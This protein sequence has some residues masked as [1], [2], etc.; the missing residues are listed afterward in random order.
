[1]TNNLSKTILTFIFSITIISLQAANITWIGASSFWDDPTNW[2]TG[3]VPSAAD[4][5]IIPS[6]WVRVPANYTALATSIHLHP[7]TNLQ[8]YPD[9]TINVDGAINKAGIENEGRIFVQGIM[10]ITNV[11]SPNGS[12]GKAI[13]NTNGLFVYSTGLLNIENIE[14]YC[15]DTRAPGYVSNSGDINISNVQSHGVYNTGTFR[16]YSVLDMSLH[17]SNPRS[18]GVYNRGAFNN[19]ANGEIYT[20]RG[21]I[22]FY[23]HYNATLDNHGRIE[24]EQAANSGFRNLAT[25]T[26]NE[27]SSISCNLAGAYGFSNSGTF[28]NY[29]QTN[30]DYTGNTALRNSGTINN[31]RT[32]LIFNSTTMGY[33]GLT[34]STFNNYKSFIVD[35]SA[36]S[37]LYGV[38]LRGSL[39]NHQDGVLS[40][41]ER[42]LALGPLDNYG[43]ISLLYTGNNNLISG[44]GAINNYSVIDDNTNCLPAGTN[45]QKLII[46]PVTGPMQV[47]VPFSNV[48]EVASLAGIN[49]NNWKIGPSNN[50]SAGTY[51]P[52]TN[53]FTP[54]ANA[55]G[56]STIYISINNGGNLSRNHTLELDSPI[57]PFTGG[58]SP[59]FSLDNNGQSFQKMEELTV[60][61]NP[62]RANLQLKSELFQE[63]PTQVQIIN[64]LGQIVFQ[65]T[66]AAGDKQQALNLPNHLA[67]GIYLL[68]CRQKGQA[69]A[70]ERIQLQK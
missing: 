28:D 57:L 45:N 67:N 30:I 36:T 37:P 10:N 9:A 41:D 51:D 68:E 23:N 39:T 12:A 47:G 2:D 53:S 49:L 7:G 32:I 21:Y 69:V 31:Y 8:I 19:Y 46:K 48:L 42:I 56:L 22:G 18:Y 20:F 1:M 27:D 11:S 34:G 17:P 63:Q 29:G 15:I 43:Y 24:C 50:T 16:N 55:V 65:R 14:D 40:I 64:S 35:V 6:G 52:L 70:V 62:T 60:F 58:D 26:N 4:H 38:Y 13:Y 59:Q 33:Y 44:N 66:Y 61:P 54:N 25:V 5:V 3:T